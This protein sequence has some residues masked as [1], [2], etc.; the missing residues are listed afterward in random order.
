MATLGRSP[1]AAPLTSADIPDSSITAA[2]I[3]TGAIT[4]ADV[5]ADMATQAELDTVSTVASA[6]LPKAGG[7]MTGAITTNS[8]FDGVDVATAVA[9]NTAKVSFTPDAA[10]VFN[11]TGADVDFRVEASGKANALF[12]QGSDGKVGMGTGTPTSPALGTSGS[13]TFLEIEN[14]GA[15]GIVLHATD[16]SQTAWEI[17]AA[18]G[19]LNIRDNDVTVIE[20]D[21]N[22]I[23]RMPKNPSFSIKVVLTDV[24]GDATV[25]PGSV[26]GSAV[27]ASN[28]TVDTEY[29]D[30]NADIAGVCF[31]APVDGM[32][33]FLAH[34]NIGDMDDQHAYGFL[35]F[36]IAGLGVTTY[37]T[38]DWYQSA[39][40]SNYFNIGWHAAHKMDANDTAFPYWAVY[41]GDK[42]VNI[43]YLYY[44]G[45]LVS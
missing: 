7:A 45:F 18:G 41:S 24:T 35:G 36:S 30:A 1:G 44:S 26:G 33:A 16:S 3:A 17:Y 14:T 43:D 20:A 13:N 27:A 21:S 2:K 8:T 32:Y 9:A 11:D 37:H 31:T 28:V 6:A 23:V 29:W 4:A 25:W 34:M 15:A 42:E 40:A 39:G 22:G 38:S 10:Q 12:V 5:A 19:K